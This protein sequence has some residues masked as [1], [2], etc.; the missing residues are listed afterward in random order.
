MGLI[1]EV[2]DLKYML[3]DIQKT[4]FK[5]EKEKAKKQN[6]NEYEKRFKNSYS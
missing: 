1:T 6:Q 3:K 5:I 2:N 4:Q